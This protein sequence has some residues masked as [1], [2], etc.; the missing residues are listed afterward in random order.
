M[1]LVDVHLLRNAVWEVLPKEIG[2]MALSNIRVA[3]V[4]GNIIDQR[5]FGTL[6]K[7]ITYFTLPISS[8]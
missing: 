5:C 1:C 3:P 7:T 4:I 6:E 8:T 2:I